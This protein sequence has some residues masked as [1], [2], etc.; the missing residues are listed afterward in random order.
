MDSSIQVSLH[1]DTLNDH[2]D[3][4]RVEFGSCGESSLQSSRGHDKCQ[5]LVKLH[6]I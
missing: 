4:Y 6:I 1:S 5:L 2:L 3:Y